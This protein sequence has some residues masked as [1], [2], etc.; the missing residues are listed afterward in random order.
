MSGGV[1]RDPLATLSSQMNAPLPQEQGSKTFL[2]AVA[3]LPGREPAP[4]GQMNFLRQWP[5]AKGGGGRGKLPRDRE[6]ETKE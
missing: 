6:P 1:R 5:E 4:Q 2:A 3:S